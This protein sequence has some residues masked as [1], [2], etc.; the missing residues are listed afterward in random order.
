[1]PGIEH[2]GQ[3]QDAFLERAQH[4]PVNGVQSSALGAVGLLSRSGEVHDRWL[5]GPRSDRWLLEWAARYASDCYDLVGVADI[6]SNDVT[7]YAW[8]ADAASYARKS[9]NLILTYRRKGDAPCA[10]SR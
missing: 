5:V 10:A 4:R 8:D 3:L 2:L 9:K 7:T 1:M 6:H